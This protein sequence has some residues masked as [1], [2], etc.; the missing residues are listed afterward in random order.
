ISGRK[1]K[2]DICVLN[3]K[4]ITLSELYGQLDPNT[5]EWTDGLLSAT[6]RSYVYSNT[7][8]NSKKDIDL[9]LKSRISDLSNVFKLDASDMTDTDD[10]IFE[11]IEKVVKVPENHNFDWQWII[12]DGPVD[13]FWVENL[14]SVLDDT[15]TLCLA[16]SE[17]IALTNKIRVIF[18]VD[19]LSQT[20]PATVSRCAM[21]YMDPVDLGWEP[22]VKSWLLKTSKIISQS[23]VDCL[24]FLIKNSVTDGLQFIKNRQKFQPYPMEDITIIITLC[25]ILDAFFDF[26]GKN[27]GFEQSNDLSDTSSK[28]ANSRRNSVIFKDIEKRDENT[29][30]P[31]K[32]PDKLTKIIQ[33]LFVFAFTWAF[34]GALNRE[35]EHRENIP[36]CPSF[37][38]DSLAKVTYDFDKLVHEL[39]GSNSQV[40]INLPTGECSIFGYFVDIEQ[41]EFI[42]WSEL[43]P[44][45]QTLIQR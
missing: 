37:E 2:V 33:K 10:N 43:V 39:F 23:G 44:N 20:S 6:I 12:L 25:R 5:M 27:G 45:D 15:R 1:G 36:F 17:R 3:P 18:E 34:G 22:Y 16:N 31:E 32:N 42:P 26:M 11:E 29:W 24:E 41:C 7:P 30:Y 8:K 38:P 4:C 14:N 40:G 21:V 13:T 19:S 28:E 9:R 35:D